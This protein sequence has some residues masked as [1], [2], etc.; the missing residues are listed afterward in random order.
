MGGAALLAVVFAFPPWKLVEQVGFG[1]F[2]GGA[3]F[4]RQ[5]R[6]GTS[7]ILAPPE[8]GLGQDYDEASRSL[9]KRG[10]ANLDIRIDWSRQ[11]R[12]LAGCAGL[13]LGLYLICAFYF[14]SRRASP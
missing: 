13:F 14:R 9:A 5:R 2:A 12:R 1:A 7:F 3:T 8:H 10:Y 4:E 6:L 11:G